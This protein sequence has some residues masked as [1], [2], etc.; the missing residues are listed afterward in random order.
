MSRTR[1]IGRLVRKATSCASSHRSIEA[2]VFELTTIEMDQFARQRLAC[3][4]RP[5]HYQPSP[6]LGEP[7]FQGPFK[8]C[9]SNA[10]VQRNSEQ[11]QERVQRSGTHPA[12]EGVHAVQ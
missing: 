10:P 2:P 8:E 11:T 6:G 12:F 3:E 1:R 9:V 4:Q 7:E 5:T